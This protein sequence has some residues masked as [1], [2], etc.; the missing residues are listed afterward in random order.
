MN[1]EIY[2]IN[3]PLLTDVA[4]FR[5]VHPGGVHRIHRSNWT[6]WLVLSGRGRVGAGA[7][8]MPLEAGSALLC[9]PDVPLDG[10]ADGTEDWVVRWVAFRSRPGLEGLLAWPDAGGLRLLRV[11][12]PAIWDHAVFALEAM[13]EAFRRFSPPRRI[14]LCFNLLEQALLWLEAAN[15]AAHPP[16]EDARILRATRYI[17]QHYS[18][19]LSVAELA[20]QCH[21]SATRFAHLFRA[22][23]G[24][25]PMKH[26]E[27]VRLEHAQRMLLGTDHALA[28]IA[29][30]CGFCNEFYF[31][32]VFR[33]AIGQSP[34][35][36]RRQ[37]LARR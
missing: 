37:R 11:A 27:A 4:H 21:L 36:F 28:H 30:E 35:Q 5:Q 9:P 8:Q 34:G 26:L 17:A 23:T 31:S 3:H 12:E 22:V 10:Q 14:D 1:H 32:A 29:R 24:S 18:R 6:L 19:R 16:A 33:R 25:T 20:G 2:Q 7:C 15:P 13:E